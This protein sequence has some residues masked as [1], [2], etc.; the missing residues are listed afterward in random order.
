MATTRLL[1]E[2]PDYRDECGCSLMDGRC[3][4]HASMMG[5]IREAWEHGSEVAGEIL[6]SLQDGYGVPGS[7]PAQGYD[8]SGIRDSSTSA[9]EAMHAAL[10]A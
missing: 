5:E 8:W 2:L 7:M 3:D 1:A 10:H 9:I 6:W 4:A